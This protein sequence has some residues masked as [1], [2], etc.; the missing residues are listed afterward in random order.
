MNFPCSSCGK[1][2]RAPLYC[3]RDDCPQFQGSQIPSEQTK[4]PDP[5]VEVIQSDDGKHH[6]TIS[7][8]GSGKRSYEIEGSTDNEKVR[9]T[10]E[11]VIKDPSTAE[12]LP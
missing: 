6:V 2:S 10:V 4:L 5:K 12:W 9:R 7:R 1:G 8:D 3:R 11:K